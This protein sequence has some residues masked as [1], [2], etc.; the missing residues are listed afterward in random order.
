MY[1][2]DPNLEP[3][4]KEHWALGRSPMEDIPQVRGA[5]RRRDPRFATNAAASVRSLYP[6]VPEYRAVRIVDIS[7]RGMKL[8]S[9]DRIQPGA[10]I[11]IKLK[12][13]FVLGEIR[14]CVQ[15]GKFFLA[16]VLVDDVFWSNSGKPIDLVTEETG[17]L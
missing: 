5:E 17:V 2:H 12:G 6:L 1:V 4:I 14:Y 15:A 11:Q 3:Y 16:G 13:V 7:K 8:R 10:G 9:K